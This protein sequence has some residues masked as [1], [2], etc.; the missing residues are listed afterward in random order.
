MVVLDRVPLR[1][2]VSTPW[3]PMIDFLTIAFSK[4]HKAR[5]TVTLSDSKVFTCHIDMKPLDVLQTQPVSIS[6]LSTLHIE[7]KYNKIDGIIIAPPLAQILEYNN[8]D[9]LKEGNEDI[10]DSSDAAGWEE[11][12]IDCVDA[13]GGKTIKP[14]KRKE[15][16]DLL[17]S[18]ATEYDKCNIETQ[19]GFSS[20][21]LALKSVV[22]TDG[23][24]DGLESVEDAESKSSNIVATISELIQTHKNTFLPKK[25]AFIQQI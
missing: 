20:I 11:S 2:N 7:S 13:I 22:Q 24:S 3:L 4:R 6:P 19:L 14:L 9:M 12:H 8:K 16:Q 1:N 25:N 5:E 15:M 10:V 23:Q 17:N 18:I 21:L